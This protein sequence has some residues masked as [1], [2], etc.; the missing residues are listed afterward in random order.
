MNMNRTK[1]GIRRIAHMLGYD[2]HRYRD[3][4]DVLKSFQF[5]TIINVGANRGQFFSRARRAAPNA[6]IYCFEPM[7]SAFQR[8]ATAVS[9][10]ARAYVYPLAVGDAPG[11]ATLLASD[12]SAASSFLP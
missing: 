9:R 10:D 3:E 2:I 6:C 11:K 4:L 5:Q 8:L 7:P 1:A 12:F